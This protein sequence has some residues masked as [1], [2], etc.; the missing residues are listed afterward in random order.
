MLSNLMSRFKNIPL[1]LVNDKEF[2]TAQEAA[3]YSGLAYITIRKMLGRKLTRY[4]FKTLTLIKK[5]ELNEL[6]MERTDG[7]KRC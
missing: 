7:T 3:E 2:L 6:L 5:E 1:G 4:K